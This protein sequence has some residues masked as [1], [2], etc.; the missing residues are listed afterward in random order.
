MASADRYSVCGCHLPF[1]FLSPISISLCISQ[2]IQKGK[3]R[4]ADQF[5]SI[6][7]MMCSV[8]IWPLCHN[9]GGAGLVTQGTNRRVVW[10]GSL[11]PVFHFDQN[12]LDVWVV[13][14]HINFFILASAPV[15]PY[16]GR[17]LIIKRRDVLI[18]GRFYHFSKLNGVCQHVIIHQNGISD[19]RIR[20]IDFRLGLQH[21]AS[22]HL[23]RP[24]LIDQICALQII[25]IALHRRPADA[26][27]VPLLW[28]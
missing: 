14:H 26:R 20:N 10:N 19:R 8:I 12:V 9:D 6:W 18:D 13:H 5:F 17:L 24:A 28:L 11:F 27:S 3:S 2:Q 7:R 1:L 22:A 23:H 15:I 4:N 25:D 21:L 16:P